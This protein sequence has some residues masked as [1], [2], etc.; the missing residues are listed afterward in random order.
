M[1]HLPSHPLHLRRPRHAS[2]SL[3]DEL[4]V[5]WEAANHALLAYSGIGP[6]AADDP[7]GLAERAAPLIERELDRLGQLLQGEI[8][9]SAA[10][11]HARHG[12]GVDGVLI[13]GGLGGAP[14]LIERLSANLDFRLAAF[15]PFALSGRTSDLPLPS[16]PRFALA[17]GAAVMALNGDPA[18]NL[19]AA[20]KAPVQER[21]RTQRGNAWPTRRIVATAAACGLLAG[22]GVFEVRTASRIAG[23]ETRIDALYEERDELRMAAHELTRNADVFDLQDR[24]ESLRGIYRSRH[25]FTPFFARV[26]DCLPEG[27]QLGRIMVERSADA[28]APAPVD[29]DASESNGV[30]N[31]KAPVLAVAILGKSRDVDDVGLFVVAL[32]RAALLNRIEVLRI[33]EGKDDLGGRW[34]EFEL[35]GQP[36]VEQQDEILAR[37]DRLRSEPVVEVAR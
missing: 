6:L 5:G 14:R 2:R 18:V 35:H 24:I 32:E 36:V 17:I 21:R 13:A 8:E 15:D 23:S 22:I 16:R 28:A 9:R 27:M 30:V 37:A 29:D 11:V 20:D 10:D 31:E 33:L 3:C 12:D 34:Y 19:L 1:G 7:D 4:A 26:V 25:L